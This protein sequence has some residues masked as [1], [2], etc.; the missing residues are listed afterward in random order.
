MAAA[1]PADRRT[2]VREM[3]VAVCMHSRTLAYD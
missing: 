1:N 2:L 3:S